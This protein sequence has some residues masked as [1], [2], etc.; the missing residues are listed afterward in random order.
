MKG[1]STRERV[2]KAYL[3]LSREID[4]A[5]ITLQK[6]ADRAKVS[7]GT[8]RYNFTGDISNLSM[9]AVKYVF[10]SG[11]EFLETHLR[12]TKGDPLKEYVKANFAWMKKYPESRYLLHFYF[13]TTT[14][15]DL[16]IRNHDYLATARSRIVRLIHESVGAGFMNASKDV[17]RLATQIHTTLIGGMLIAAL[18]GSDQAISR[19][20]TMTLESVDRMVERVSRPGK[21]VQL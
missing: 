21:A 3:E 20:M 19:Q 18:E 14:K 8:V 4:L 12:T 1:L 13:L 6:V 9:E 16:P 17:E 10:A 15:L 7:F 2:I 11:Y 5:G